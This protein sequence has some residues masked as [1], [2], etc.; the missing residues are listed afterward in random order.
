[1]SAT[2][3]AEAGKPAKEPGQLWVARPMWD[4]KFP[5]DDFDGRVYV[6]LGDGGDKVY[7]DGATYKT[8][9]IFIPSL[10]HF[11]RWNDR[12]MERD[13]FIGSAEE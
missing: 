10:G 3:T 9:T 7:S 12:E 13:E 8:W 2:G 1:M 4:G 5:I 11:G 6:I